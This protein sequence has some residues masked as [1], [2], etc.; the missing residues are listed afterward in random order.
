[1]IDLT[2][3]DK[4]FFTIGEVSGVTGVKPYILRY[5]ESEFRPLKPQ[6]NTGGQRVYRRKDVELILYIKKLLYE[7]KFTIEGAKQRLK[8]ERNSRQLELFREDPKTTAL[9]RLKHQLQSLAEYLKRR[10]GNDRGVAQR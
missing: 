10:S 4:L 1:M 2:I 9:I 6:K 5:W 8:D 7:E 3:P